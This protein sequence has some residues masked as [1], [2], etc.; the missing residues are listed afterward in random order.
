M[1]SIRIP[2]KSDKYG[3]SMDARVSWD[4]QAS[5]QSPKPI[6]LVYHGG[7]LIVGSSEMI[8]HAQTAYLSAHN[9]LVVAP[10][11]RLAPQATAAEAFAD[12]EEAYDW[13]TTALPAALAAAH[14]LLQ[15]DTSRVVAYGHSFGGTLALHVGGAK[16]VKAVT[17]FYPSL[18]LADATSAAHA[19]ARAPLFATAA[20]F[21]PSKADWAAIAPAAT[22]LCEA[23]LAL[24]G[25]TVPEPRNKWQMHLLKHGQWLSTLQPDGE[26]A[27]L[28]PLTRV[29]AQWPPVLIVQSAADE[30]PGSNVGLAR[31]AEAEMRAAGVAEVRV[32][33]VEGEGHMFDLP[34]SVGTTDLGARW[35]AVVEGLEWLCGRV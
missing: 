26:Y 9:F 8:P 13:A 33:V 1:E 2:F 18:F 4:N 29:R 25:T 7:G 23:P 19:P 5:P 34:A 11:Y 22:Q 24:P 30:V 20:D 6:A 31:R 3:N 21:A 15:V 16:N 17:A 27:V 10:N 35:G 12:C 32:V 28:N 14:A